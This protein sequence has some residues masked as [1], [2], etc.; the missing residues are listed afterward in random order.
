MTFVSNTELAGPRNDGA[1]I[2]STTRRQFSRRAV[3]ILP[4][5]VLNSI[6]AGG[7]FGVRLLPGMSTFSP[8]ILSIMI[9]IAFP[10]IVGPP[11]WGQTGV[12]F[13]LRWG[14]PGPLILLGLQLPAS[15]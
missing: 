14:L 10:N 13:S 15:Q 9:G 3:E 12:T 11:P 1:R 6:V 2:P 8:M 5:L 4:G 7:A